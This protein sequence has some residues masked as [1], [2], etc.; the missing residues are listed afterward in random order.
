ME[1]S[2]KFKQGYWLE[3]TIITGAKPEMK[4]ASEEIFGPLLSIISF[5]DEVEAIHISNSV[6]Y[7][8][9]GSVWTS[10]GARS[11][12][13]VK[14]LKTGI[15][16]VNSMLSGYPQIPVP[17]QKMSGTGVELGMEGLMTYC[18]LKSAV[19]AYDESVPVGWDIK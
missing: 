1:M 4:V 7:G 11:M 18:K 3:P 5:K 12:R 16:W 19:M 14:S 8:L 10:N 17:P 15:I 2:D 9:S 6:I 13:M